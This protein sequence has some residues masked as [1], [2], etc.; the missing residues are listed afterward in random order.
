MLDAKQITGDYLIPYLRNTDVQWDWINTDDL[1]RM[2]IRPDEYSRYTIKKGDLL[3]CE[4]GEVGRAAIW[5][6]SQDVIGYQKALHRLRPL[7]LE[8]DEPAFCISFYLTLQRE[9][10]SMQMAAKIPSLTSRGRNYD[11]TASRFHLLENKEPLSII[12]T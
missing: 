4:G 3:V 9:V 1:P 8:R 10:Y 11:V 12:S 2:D 5:G 7:K 6:G